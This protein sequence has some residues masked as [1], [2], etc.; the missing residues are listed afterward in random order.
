MIPTLEWCSHYKSNSFISFHYN[1]NSIVCYSLPTS[2]LG[3]SSD[4]TSLPGS[5]TNNTLVDSCFHTVEHF[6]VELGQLVFLVGRSFLDIPERGCIDDIADNETLDSLILR[7]GLSSRYTTN[8]LN[9][10]TPLLVTSVIAPL[11]SH[12]YAMEY[13]ESKTKKKKK[14]KER[15]DSVR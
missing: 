12:F 15:E 4:A 1:N 10:S 3:R 9:V 14:K 11:D 6:Q 2:K 13:T 8:S 7:N 5:S